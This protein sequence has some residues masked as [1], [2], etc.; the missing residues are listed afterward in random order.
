M[1]V[2]DLSLLQSCSHGE[3]MHY[4]NQ[5]LPILVQPPVLCKFIHSYTFILCESVTIGL[6]HVALVLPLVFKFVKRSYKLKG[7]VTRG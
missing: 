2:F 5:V 4:N 1:I 3:R 7:R 6:A